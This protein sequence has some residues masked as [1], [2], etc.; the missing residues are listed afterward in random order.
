MKIYPIIITINACLN[1]ISRAKVFA[2]NFAQKISKF[3]YQRLDDPGKDQ[4]RSVK[5]LP[6]SFFTLL[7]CP[8]PPEK[9]ASP[10]YS[11]FGLLPESEIPITVS[12]DD[13]AWLL[14]RSPAVSENAEMQEGHK[15][16][17]AQVGRIFLSWYYIIV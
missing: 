7:E 8:T 3:R 14:A 12:I 11:T 15:Q 4:C 5:Q 16:S 10:K 9:P 2:I 17:R 1:N 6:E 13:F